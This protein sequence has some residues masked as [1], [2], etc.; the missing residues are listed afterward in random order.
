[1]RRL[2]LT[3]VSLFAFASP[4]PA[5]YNMLLPDKWETK[6]DEPVTFTYQWGH[7][8]EHQLFDAPAPESVVVIAPDGK[9]TDVTKTLEKI[10]VP[11]GEQKVAAYRFKLTPDQ[12]G[13]YVVFL[14]T[15][16][17]WM[18]DEEEFWKDT[19]KVVLHVQAQKGWDHD[20]N[21]GSRDEFQWSPLTRPYGLQPGMVFQAKLN[22][23]GRAVPSG[24]RFEVERYNAVAPAKLPPDEQITRTGN[25]DP[26]GVATGT[27]TEAGWW[28]LTGILK[29]GTDTQEHDGKR[30]SVR[31][32]TTLWVYVDEKPAK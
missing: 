5:H 9:S 24:E 15:P 7:P 10:T 19:V 13:D 16:P 2:L 1:L 3:L 6:K 14:K 8:F 4:S 25:F 22:W 11:S 12:R 28:A 18:K 27:L 20:A 23:G 29:H 26:N 32:R 21:D 31:K 17:I 30:Y